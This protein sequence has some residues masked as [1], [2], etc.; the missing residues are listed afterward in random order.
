M[1]FSM[2]EIIG[3]TTPNRFAFLLLGEDERE[4]VCPCGIRESC[5]T[6]FFCFF[7]SLPVCVILFHNIT[8]PMTDTLRAGYQPHSD[9]KEMKQPR[10]R[11]GKGSQSER[12]R[13]RRKTGERQAQSAIFLLA[14][15]FSLSGSKSVA[16][17]RKER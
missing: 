3:S 9:K 17:K 16:R 1:C 13:R 7:R 8:T 10:E 11:Q 12:V 5:V 6:L 14:S 15:S 4:P 2:F